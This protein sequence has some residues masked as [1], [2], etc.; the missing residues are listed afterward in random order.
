[1]LQKTMFAS[2]NQRNRLQFVNLLL[3]TV[4]L[5]IPDA[6]SFKSIVKIIWKWIV[7]NPMPLNE[8][9]KIPMNECRH[10]IHS[11]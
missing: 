4:P 2:E 7:M 3:D 9:V 10:S 1:M 5:W 6:S 8:L 11:S